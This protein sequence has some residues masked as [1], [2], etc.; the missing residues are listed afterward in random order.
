VETLH[1]W[2]ERLDQQS[3]HNVMQVLKQRGVSVEAKKDP[4]ALGKEHRV[5]E[6][7]Q[8]DQA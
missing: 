4:C 5:S 7:G 6:I 1:V 2:R 3:K 8:V